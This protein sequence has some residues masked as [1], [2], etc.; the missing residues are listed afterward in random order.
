[1]KL[2]RLYP[3]LDS[4]ALARCG[5][6]PLTA[7]DGL[8]EAGVEMLQFR[9]K[10]EYTR[11]VFGVAEKIS[12]L[13]RPS[14]V[15]FIVNDRADIAALL[16]AGLHLGQDD[17]PPEYAR[18]LLGPSRTIGFSTHNA[19]QM[20][21]A[22]Q[23]PVDYVALGPIFSTVSKDRPDPVVG[24]DG[25]RA[26]RALMQRPLVA[27]G[28]IT[29]ETAYSVLDAGADSLAVIGGLLTAECTKAAVRHRAEEWLASLNSN[30]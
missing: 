3:I 1:M 29:I 15:H 4:T 25:L 24:L 5:C 8:L 28:G 26:C 10:G 6:T 17:L 13:C 20:V 11:E 14:G 21:A 30:R 9:H 16:D 2:P 12:S 23:E 18:R 22:G 19:A 7:A 27:I